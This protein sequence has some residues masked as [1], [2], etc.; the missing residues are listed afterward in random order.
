MSL[1]FDLSKIENPPEGGFWTPATPT[2][3]EDVV[4]K[5]KAIIF[6]TIAVGMGEI[7]RENAAEFYARCH[8]IELIDGPS[9]LLPDPDNEGY[10]IE[11]ELTPQDIQDHIGLTTNVFPMESRAKWISRHMA[12]WMADFRETYGKSIEKSSKDI[13]AEP[14]GLAFDR[15]SSPDSLY[16]ESGKLRET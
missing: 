5:T 15:D 10:F 2:A 16:D 14:Y 4:P 12:H 11:S 7:T 13:V 3:G 6:K 9:L 8:L 1:N